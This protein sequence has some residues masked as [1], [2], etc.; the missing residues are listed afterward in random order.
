[1]NT[2]VVQKRGGAGNSA[3]TAEHHKYS[4]IARSSRIEYPTG[5]RSWLAGR[6]SK[7][8]YC[9]LSELYHGIRKQKSV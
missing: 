9:K 7:F 5:E 1:M 6:N 3:S 2:Y 4:G 8:Y